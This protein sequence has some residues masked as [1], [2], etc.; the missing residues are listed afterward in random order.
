MATV[1]MDRLLQACVEQDAS[2]IHITVGKPPVF[3]LHGRLRALE[4]K[5]L[6]ADDATALM[7]SI[8]PERNQQELL[9]QFLTTVTLILQLLR[10][11]LSMLLLQAMDTLLS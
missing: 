5:V 1:N 11:I 7:K 3:R 10:S 6:T 8:T 2:D 9:L 4:T